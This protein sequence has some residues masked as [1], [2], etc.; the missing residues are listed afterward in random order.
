LSGAEG[1]VDKKRS[2]S[3]WGYD[4]EVNETTGASAGSLGAAYGGGAYHDSK[5]D[6]VHVVGLLDVDALIGVKLGFDISFEKSGPGGTGSGAPGA[7]APGLAG[8]ITTGCMTVLIG[9]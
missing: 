8:T 5:D 3:L 9:G 4:V 2:Y 1:Q 7:G 6:R